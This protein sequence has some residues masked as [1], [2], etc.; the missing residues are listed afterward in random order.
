MTPLSRSP[1]A[2]RLRSLAFFLA[3]AIVSV[4]FLP[5]LILLAAPIRFGWPVLRAFVAVHLWLLRWICGVRY[6]VT[7]QENL[8]AGASLLAVRH[9]SMWE[10]MFLPYYL[11]NPAVV[12]KQEILRYPFIG[13]ICRK[14]GYIGVD[15][16]GDVSAARATFGHARRAAQAGRQVLI[17]PAGTRR[18]EGRDKMQPGVAVLYRQM[19]LPCVPITHNAADCWPYKSWLRPPGEIEVRILPPV[20]PGL[21]T[22]EVMEALTEALG[23]GQRPGG[24]VPAPVPAPA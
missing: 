4:I 11:D 15:R 21:R 5:L 6:R 18:P 13:P 22:R 7:G 9:E 16:T 2:I 20:P 14:L 3:S 19:D 24:P 1:A 8:P 12:L 23:P 17:F 10:T